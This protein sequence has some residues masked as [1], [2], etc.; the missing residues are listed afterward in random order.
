MNRERLSST[1]MFLRPSSLSRT[2]S[3]PSNMPWSKQ[4]GQSQ[5]FISSNY[6]L[7]EC[8][9]Q[10][11]HKMRIVSSLGGKA[12]QNFSSAESRSIHD[13]HGDGGR[14]KKNRKVMVA[15]TPEKAAESSQLI[16]PARLS[17]VI[18]AIELV[19]T[20]LLHDFIV[21]AD[22][23]PNGNPLRDKIAPLSSAH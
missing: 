5:R 6:E 20:F 4:S 22:D 8:R 1:G 14:V 18:A 13:A 23:Q 15:N 10:E 11:V 17:V 9:D 19:V 12:V 3:T 7:L 16:R 21:K 2:V